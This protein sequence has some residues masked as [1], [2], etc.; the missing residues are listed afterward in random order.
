MGGDNPHGNA[1]EGQ[2]LSGNGNENVGG[3]MPEE[4]MEENVNEEL[5]E[6]QND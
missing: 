3:D 2:E 4:G 5:N 6:D 1:M